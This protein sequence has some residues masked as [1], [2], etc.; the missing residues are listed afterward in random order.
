[1]CA[2]GDSYNELIRNT[3]K[4]KETAVSAMRKT[5]YLAKESLDF[6]VE[7]KMMK[8]NSL[9]KDQTIKVLYEEIKFREN[10]FVEKLEKIFSGDKN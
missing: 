9:I 7:N 5:L 6:S 2:N 3:Y 10:Y 4:D 1:M 8:L